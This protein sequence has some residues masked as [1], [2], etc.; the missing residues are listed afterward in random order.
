MSF[1]RHTPSIIVYDVACITADQSLNISYG[2][3][4][5]SRRIYLPDT[6]KAVNM[7]YT[8]ANVTIFSTDILFSY[9]AQI[10]LLSYSLAIFVA[11]IILLFG[12]RALWINRVSHSSSFSAILSTTRN[13]E[14]DALVQGNIALGAQPLEKSL[15]KQKLQFGV[16]QTQNGGMGGGS[17]QHTAFGLEGSVVRLRYKNPSA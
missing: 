14:L 15:A 2:N 13:A 3:L 17:E 1:R 11:F 4:S 8:S 10:L 16:L 7:T 12:L 5:D 6:K 9:N